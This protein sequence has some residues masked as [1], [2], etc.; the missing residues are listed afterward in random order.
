MVRLVLDK[1][2][3]LPEG[4]VVDLVADNENDDLKDEER[5]DLHEALF[6]SWPSAETGRLR[7]SSAILDDFRQRR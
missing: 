5:R 3:T 7:T 4:T 1:P 2:T 6:A